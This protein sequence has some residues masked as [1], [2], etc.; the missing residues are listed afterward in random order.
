MAFFRDKYPDKVSV[1]TIGQDV[2]S[3]FFSKELCG[4]PHVNSTGEIGP[5]TIKKE[6]AVGAGIRRVY[7]VLTG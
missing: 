1:Y 3:G 2:N 5:V 6:E 7:I 4:G